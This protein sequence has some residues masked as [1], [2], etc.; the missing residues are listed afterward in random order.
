MVGVAALQTGQAAKATESTFGPTEKKTRP[1]NLLLFFPDEMR[2]QAQEFMHIDQTHTPNI[3][4]FARESCVMRQMVSNYPLCTPARGSFM[5]GQ[6]PMHD[7]MTGNAHSYGRL[8]G[9]NLSSSLICW[10]DVLKKQGYA[11]GYVGKWHLDAP[12]APYV[13]SYN[14]PVHGIKWNEWT[15]PERRHGFDFWY[16][17]GAYDQRLK[18][19]YW[20]ND[21]DRE[22]PIY[23]NQW[24]PE[25]DVDIAIRYLKNEGGKYRDSAKPFALAVSMSPPHSP[26]NQT[27]QKYLDLYKGMTPKELN[28]RPTVDWDKKYPNGF[29]PQ[30]MNSYLAMVNGVDEQ[31]GRILQELDKQG[32]SND[33]LVVFFSDHGCCMGAH[34]EPTKNNPF[35]ESMRIPMMFRLPGVIPQRNDDL[36]MSMPDLYPT[37]LGLLGFSREVPDTVEG[38]DWSNRVRT[39]KGAEATSQL[40][41]KI[42][43]GLSSFGKRGVRTHEHTLVIERKNKQPLQYTLYDNQRDP[44]QQK[45]IA[46]DNAALIAKLVKSELDPWLEK[47]V[48]S[49]RSAPFDTNGIKNM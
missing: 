30:H 3:N 22:H 43:Y 11:L 18:P 40:Y 35:E 32:L 28:P 48:D 37:M 23:I 41:L 15:A 27:P 9:I 1:L 26:Y 4:R 46:A 33:T 19:M 13:K 29:G 47:T 45:N 17:Y 2:A 20:T 10:S 16:S 25:H 34:G 38:T 49:W 42:P 12:Y 24:E 14:N 39:G 5:T 44:Y 6:Y 21:T 7:G 31:F 8:V 36:L